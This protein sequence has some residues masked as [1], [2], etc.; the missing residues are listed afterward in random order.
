MKHLIIG[1]TGLIGTYI[2]KELLRRGEP[3]IGTSQTSR[4]GCWK[5][6]IRDHD[7]VRQMMECLLPD[8]VYLCAATTDVDLCE[9]EPSCARV[10]LDGARNVIRSVAKGVRLVFMSSGYVFSGKEDQLC[11]ELTKP[12][13]INEYGRCKRQVEIEIEECKR[14][15]WTILRM[16]HV[17]GNRP[18]NYAAAWVRALR[19]GS[20]ITA[21]ADE[22][23]SPVHAHDVAVAAIDWYD[24]IAHVCGPL[25]TR[26]HFAWELADVFGFDKKNIIAVQR[27]LGAPRPQFCKLAPFLVPSSHAPWQPRPIHKSG[28]FRLFGEGV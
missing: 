23:G 17:Y 9:R 27:V 11:I 10:N 26:Y 21:D 28:S 6:D 16:L 5:L 4:V 8:V 25:R 18:T 14:D 2:Y 12:E 22:W 19:E 3:V 7:A 15:N 13:P 20:P 1:T 24:R